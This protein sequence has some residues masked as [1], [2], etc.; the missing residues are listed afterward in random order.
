MMKQFNTTRAA[1]LVATAAVLLAASTGIAAADNA[2]PSTTAQPTQQQTG[3]TAPVT[4]QPV[5]I[6]PASAST[7]PTQ[8]FKTS[9]RHGA[10]RGTKTKPH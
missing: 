10:E 2:T 1:W 8:P 5:T 9:T 4:P 7:S 3:I 6:V